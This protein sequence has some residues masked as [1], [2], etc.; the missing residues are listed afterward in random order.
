LHGAVIERR[1]GK[2][3]QTTPEDGMDISKS[4]EEK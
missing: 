2:V 1:E 4:Y 3:N